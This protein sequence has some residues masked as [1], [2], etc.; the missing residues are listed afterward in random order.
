MGQSPDH[1]WHSHEHR[2]HLCTWLVVIRPDTTGVVGRH[3]HHCLPR[4]S[5]CVKL[6]AQVR[7]ANTEVQG[8]TRSLPLST[9]SPVQAPAA[10][11]PEAP[12]PPP[13]P[14]L[15]TACTGPGTV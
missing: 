2:P 6:L 5:P 1:P 15:A 7:T 10:H 9:A 4:S 13:G 8:D 14:S 3:R 12:S 11:R